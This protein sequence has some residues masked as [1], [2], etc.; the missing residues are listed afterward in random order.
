MSFW[1]LFLEA[2]LLVQAVMVLLVLMSILSWAL[3]YQRRKI[4]QGAETEALKF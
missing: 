2:S 1:G 3:I 4:L